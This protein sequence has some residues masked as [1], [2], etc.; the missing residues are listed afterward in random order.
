MYINEVMHDST[1]KIYAKINNHPILL[2][3]KAMFGMPVGL[4]VESLTYFDKCIEII[5][6]CEVYVKNLRDDRTYTFYADSILPIMTKYGQFHLIRCDKESAA[7]N[8]RKAERFDVTKMGLISINNQDMRNVIVYDISMS[9]IAVILDKYTKCQ[10]GDSITIQFR[11]DNTFHLYTVEGV[12]VREFDVKGHRA[13]GCRIDSLESDV[14]QMITA[15]RAEAHRLIMEKESEKVT[16]P[17]DQKADSEIVKTKESSKQEKETSSKGRMLS[18]DEQN[19]IL[20]PTLNP[21]HVQTAHNLDADIPEVFKNNEMNKVITQ[22]NLN[23]LDNY[24]SDPR[25]N[26]LFDVND[27]DEERTILLDELYGVEELE[28]LNNIRKKGE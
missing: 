26:P 22:D 8:R 28:E 15:K 16:L 27:D 4:L 13:I 3:T 7:D 11:I 20:S 23:K 25:T 2:Y 19:S 14:V 10:K 5:D 24:D 12:M 18:A 9:G 1:I 21:Q 17:F 6:P